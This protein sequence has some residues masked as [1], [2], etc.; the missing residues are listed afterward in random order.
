MKGNV[1]TE[2]SLT[3]QLSPSNE[4]VLLV[5][6]E[7]LPSTLL[8]ELLLNKKKK[9]RKLRLGKEECAHQLCKSFKKIA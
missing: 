4:K 5:M 2:T 1:A 6:R 9:A 3:F 8:M 7:V